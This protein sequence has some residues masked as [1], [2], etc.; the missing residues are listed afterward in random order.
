MDQ[1]KGA[2]EKSSSATGQPETAGNQ[3]KAANAGHGSPSPQRRL[4]R[5]SRGS[6]SPTRHGR[7]PAAPQRRKRKSPTSPRA[8]FRRLRGQQERVQRSSP[9]RT[10]SPSGT[11]KRSD[12]AGPSSEKVPHTLQH[13]PRQINQGPGSPSVDNAAMAA[14]QHTGAAAASAVRTAAEAEGGQCHDGGVKAVVGALHSSEQRR[15]RM[16]NEIR[17]GPTSPG[18]LIA[19]SRSPS[20][21]NT[22]LRLIATQIQSP[23]RPGSRSAEK[24]SS[25]TAISNRPP[26]H[27]FYIAVVSGTLLVVVLLLGIVRIAWPQSK[28]V[29]GLCT[30]H[31]CRAYANELVSSINPAVEPCHNFTL[32][33]C[34]GWQRLHNL[35]V[36]EDQFQRFLSR[37]DKVF[38]S[39]EAPVSGQND[40]QRAAVLYLSCEDILQGERNELAAVKAALNEAG[41]IWPQVSQGGDALRTLLYSSINLGWDAVLSFDV[42]SGS[43]QMVDELVVGPGRSFFLLLSM[44][45][46][47]EASSKKR[48]YFDVLKDNLQRSDARN[49]N[50]VTFKQM[51]LVA[52]PSLDN[53]SFYYTVGAWPHQPAPWLVNASRAGLTEP[54]WLEALRSVNISLRGSVRIST[55]NIAYVET[56]LLLWEELGEDTFHLFVSWCTVQVAAF[57]ANKDLI[58]NYYYKISER[59]EV[60]HRAFCLTR[61][62]L[63][64][65][66]VTFARYVAESLEENAAVVAKEIALSVRLAFSQ[67]LS[68]WSHFDEKVTVVANWSSLETAFRNF[69]YDKQ[70]NATYGAA[71]VQMPDMSSSFVSNWRHY[72]LLKNPDDVMG[73]VYAIY[74][75]ETF[76]FEW[77]DQDFQLMHY[78]LSYP[79]FDPDLPAPVNYGGF[80]SEVAGSLGA[81]LLY[82]YRDH[83]NVS[84][85]LFDC[86]RKSLTGS[87]VSTDFYLKQAVGYRALIDAYRQ[88]AR[89]TAWVLQGLERYS[90]LQLVFMATCFGLCPGSHQAQDQCRLLTLY[91]EFAEAFQCTPRDLSHASQ[92]CD[93]L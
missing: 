35:D 19:P 70:G 7:R 3:L 39:V 61:T 53:L 40:E 89:P 36:W 38:K 28:T 55:T 82:S 48:A 43:G 60:Y 58:M 74:N 26:R 11:S 6:L 93:L 59:A 72:R 79:F 24:R 91:P 80:G 23:K 41:I 45:A 92:E 68:S 71:S 27:E 12:G 15:S 84:Q 25:S 20:T 21:A 66:Q 33:V 34:D 62:V 54:R 76:T 37:L 51:Q 2:S 56:L 46:G 16:P 67:R 64:F 44:P 49:S 57:Y 31:A 13:L 73:L 69:Q 52:E 32:F 8:M 1:L 5:G 47:M 90:D 63:F 78:S 81:M 22:P 42:V 17:D 77:K 65:R 18:L 83:G 10:E 88:N 29:T 9:R 50:T 85:S 30:T 75:L 86:V 14:N 4:E 87:T